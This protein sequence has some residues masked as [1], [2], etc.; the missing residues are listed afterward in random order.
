LGIDVTS[1]DKSYSN[2]NGTKGIMLI[3][4]IA[5]I[6]VAYTDEESSTSGDKSKSDVNDKKGM[7]I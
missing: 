7:L 1:E 4:C 3:S 2:V 6:F 5:N